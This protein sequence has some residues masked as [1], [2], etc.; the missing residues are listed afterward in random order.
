M[1]VLQSQTFT[2]N[3]QNAPAKPSSEQVK[4]DE[5]ELIERA[6]AGDGSAFDEMTK[7]YSEKAYSIAY[8]M[9]A[10][11]DDARDLVQD[12]F[13]EV[14]RTL[15]RFNTQY[16]FS[17]WL[18]RILI[19]KC[20]NYRKREARRRMLSF[21]DFWSGRDHDSRQPIPTYPASTGVTPHEILENKELRHSI[22]EALN[23]LS[24]R[25][26]TVVV[27]F[28]IEGLSHRQIAEILQCPEGTVMS[29]LHHGRL[30][31]KHILSKRLNGYFQ[32]Y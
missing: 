21:T 31:L 4:K 7:R 32:Q 14:F 6:K 17:T 10:S 27:L 16:R 18:Y 2:K 5:C 3:K 24:E 25:H 11:P 12:A 8:Q 13:L 20:I 22:L 28:D 30:K 9:L 15:E 23:S 26:R 29:R 19:N 1:K